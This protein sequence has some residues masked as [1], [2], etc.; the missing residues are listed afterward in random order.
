MGGA[1]GEEL[2]Q[3]EKMPEAP[4]SRTG[5]RLFVMG[6]DGAGWRNVKTLLEQ[7]RLP[8]LK[9]LI[10]KT[11]LNPFPIELH[12]M[13]STANSWVR[14]WTGLDPDQTGA[15]GNGNFT[16]NLDSFHSYD[17]NLNIFTSF[18]GWIRVIP[19][20]H[21]VPGR[22]GKRGVQIG[23]FVSKGGN[24]GGRE[25][26]PLGSVWANS[27]YKLFK[28][29]FFE[30]EKFLRNETASTYSVSESQKNRCPICPTI[31][32]SPS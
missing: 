20:E 4:V 23:W 24:V 29:P 16:N 13:T 11:G 8:N 22:L 18:G 3:T 19:F 25:H 1:E 31:V 17:S 14:A 26:S 5:K 27:K 15:S 10:E 9:G 12:G 2:F 6:W 30:D 21:T 28:K 32:I 7:N